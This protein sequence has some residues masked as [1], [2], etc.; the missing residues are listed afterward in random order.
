MGGIF[1]AMK[2]LDFFRAVLLAPLAKFF[3]WKPTHWGEAVESWTGELSDGPDHDDWQRL[4]AHGSHLKAELTYRHCLEGSPLD[5]LRVGDA[6]IV[7]E[8]VM[9]VTGIEAI[10]WPETTLVFTK[11]RF[12]SSGKPRQLAVQTMVLGPHPPN[13][14]VSWR[15]SQSTKLGPRWIAVG[16]NRVG[17]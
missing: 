16:D 10:D 1:V 9:C 4:W 5:E 17:L 3:G 7:N 11:L 12:G 2:R 8:H 13:H 6:V 15:M 14:F